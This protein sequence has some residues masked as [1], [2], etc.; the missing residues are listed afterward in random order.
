MAIKLFVIFI[1]AVVALSLPVSI[2]YASPESVV[3][4]RCS[5]IK[6]ALHQQRQ[7][8]LVTRINR[9]R[10]YQTLIDQL[11]ALTD[12]VNNNQMAT[13]PFEQQLAVL[14]QEFDLFRAAYTSYDDGLRTLLNAD[15]KEKPG[16]FLAQLVHIRQLRAKIDSHEKV[17][18]SI[19]GRYREIIIN[20]QQE[21]ERLRNAV[22]G[23]QQ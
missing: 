17:I 10:A 6:I 1:L 20:L 18:A 15:C 4:D 21:L 23:E 8:D 7:R 12:R 13:Q 2:V 19:L 14:K 3:S 11:Q 22:L 5:S 9:G 16:D